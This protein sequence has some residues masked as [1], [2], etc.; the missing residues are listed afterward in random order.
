MRQA[1]RHFLIKW[2][3]KRLITSIKKKRHPKLSYFR[4]GMNGS[5]FC[6][7]ERYELQ[8]GPKAFICDGKGTDIRRDILPNERDFSSITE[9]VG[10]PTPTFRKYVQILE[11][12]G[13]EFLKDGDW[14]TS[15]RS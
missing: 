9:E 15:G 11:Q 7:D 8:I 5:F 10:I 13:Y 6:I 2:L 14:R 4:K 12:N 3:L 1:K